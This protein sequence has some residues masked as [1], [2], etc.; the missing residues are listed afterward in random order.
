M[1]PAQ[2]CTMEAAQVHTKH[3]GVPSP[4][5]SMTAVPCKLKQTSLEHHCTPENAARL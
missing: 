2:S 4:C 3:G 5:F 1:P